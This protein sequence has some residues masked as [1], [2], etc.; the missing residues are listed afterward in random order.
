MK[1]TSGK[2]C[3]VCGHFSLRRGACAYCGERQSEWSDLAI[4]SAPRL[5]TLR[6]PMSGVRRER[7]RRCSGRAQFP[8]SAFEVMVGTAGN[9][10][11][12]Y[13]L[14]CRHRLQTRCPRCGVYVDATAWIRGNRAAI[15][16]LARRRGG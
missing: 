10:P 16:R 13:P 6:C 12:T 5:V 14:G 8:A 3:I 15:A 11:A 1:R 9:G 4:V 7:G 2:P